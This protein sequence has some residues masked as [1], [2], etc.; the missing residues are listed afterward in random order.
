MR[1]LSVLQERAVPVTAGLTR[2]AGR[3]EP[4]PLEPGSVQG[5]LQMH[6][7]FCC[8]TKKRNKD[9]RDG[10]GAMWLVAVGTQTQ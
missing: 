10:H 4:R 1:G 6:V 8:T 5:S 3:S 9:F 7:L 2:D